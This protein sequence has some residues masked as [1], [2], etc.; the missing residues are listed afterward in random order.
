MSMRKKIWLTFA[1]ILVLTAV[2]ILIDYPKGPDLHIGN[3]NKEIKV[4]LGLDLQGGTHLVYDTD[5]SQIASADQ[6]A[7]VEGVRDVIERRVNAFGISE[8]VVQTNKSTNGWKIIVELAGISD[9]NEAIKMIGET[10]L[11]DFKE[12]K[13]EEL[14]TEQ[15]SAAEEANTETKK[16]AE[17]VLAKVLEPNADF[18]A[19]ANEYTQDTA[20]VNSETQEK[21]G[22]DLGFFTRDQMLTEIANVVFDSLKDNETYP[23]L[24]E[25]DYGYHILRRTGTEGDKA[26]ASQIFF[27]K[28]ATVGQPQL[29]STGLSGKQLK[30]AAVEFN[31]QTNETQVSL[32]FNEEGKD[33]FAQ[34]T[35][36][37][38]NKIVGIYLD[39]NPISLPRV[40]S[41]I[42]NGQA[43]ISGSFTLEEAKLLAQ[44]LNAGA[45]PI[46][47]MLVSQQIVGPSL[48]KSSVEKSFVAG[49]IGLV[50][51]S[52]FMIFYYR[53]PG[54]LSVA[55]LLI[56]TLIS[57]A[58]FKLIPVTLTLAGVAGFILSIGMAVD[59]NVLIFE[60][61]REEIRSG[62][63]LS[64]AIEEGF[65]RAWP[66]I[67]DSNISSLIS[68]VILSWFGTTTI[69]GFAITLGIG[70]LV[71][72]FSAITVTRNFMRIIFSKWLEQ[73]HQLFTPSA[74]QK[75]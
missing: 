5:T 52:F 13:T 17:E 14:T 34:I 31:Q 6:A 39:G 15:V 45:L 69:K 28:Q 35:E 65:K 41:V 16:N 72:L 29:V 38:L 2:C 68:C 46:P 59:A 58:I 57:L 37:N 7:A 1:G 12:E 51:V 63:N 8:P 30:R 21:S 61:S 60:R 64:V 33:L 23:S 44:R 70:V 24:V 66:S 54:L 20:N 25:T 11:L 9:V 67:R 48:G 74:K 71:S 62:K 18:T 50:L 56:Y 10:P 3:L 32:E 36:R 55:A 53:L 47:I 73:Q 26:R 49:I 42:T 40:D 4:H 19:L 43:V 27:E 22:G 75:D